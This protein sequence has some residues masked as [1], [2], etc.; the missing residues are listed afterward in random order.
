MFL[1]EMLR[2]GKGLEVVLERVFGKVLKRVL[3][4]VWK[5]C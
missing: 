3:R 5:V 1:N 4:Q 2:L